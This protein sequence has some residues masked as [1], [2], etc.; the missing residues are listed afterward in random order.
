MKKEKTGVPGLYLRR[1]NITL[2]DIHRHRRL[3]NY[4]QLLYRHSG[5]AK[6]FSLFTNQILCSISHLSFVPAFLQTYTLCRF[7]ELDQI[8]IDSMK[9]SLPFI[10]K[11]SKGSSEREIPALP[12]FRPKLLRNVDPSSMIF[13]ISY[14]KYKCDI[15]RAKQFIELPTIKNILDSTHIFRH[16]E[17]SFKKSQG[18]TN[19]QISKLMG[20]TSIKTTSKYIHEEFKF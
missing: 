14:D 7:N 3:E 15:S 5:I 19:L 11:S 4:L 6:T 18:F 1:L 17:A 12:D 8:N 13:V 20:H 2:P 16:L 10:I 9:S